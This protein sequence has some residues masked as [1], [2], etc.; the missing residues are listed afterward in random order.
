MNCYK[1]LTTNTYK[2]KL[3]FARAVLA[4]GLAKCLCLKSSLTIV[5]EI[6]SSKVFMSQIPFA[7]CLIAII[8]AYQGQW[9]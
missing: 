9:T 6:N 3:L 7:H 4:D 2:N 1:G 8:D 5:A